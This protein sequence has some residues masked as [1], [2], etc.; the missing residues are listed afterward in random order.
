MENDIIFGPLVIIVFHTCFL[1]ITSSLSNTSSGV[2]RCCL[3]KSSIMALLSCC[4][5]FLLASSASFNDEV[6][7]N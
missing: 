5:F 2:S 7:K 4:F 3:F 1:R 6:D